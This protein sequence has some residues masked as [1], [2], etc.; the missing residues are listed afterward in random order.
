MTRRKSSAAPARASLTAEELRPYAKSIDEQIRDCEACIDRVKLAS[1]RLWQTSDGAKKR[2]LDA[3]ECKVLSQLANA[4]SR[5][6]GELRELRIAKVKQ[7]E[8]P[9]DEAQ[10]ETQAIEFL[11]GRGW[12]VDR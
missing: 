9:V 5:A 6:H 4:E 10:L 8:P 1:E 7:P 3:E 2:F 11:R 12:K